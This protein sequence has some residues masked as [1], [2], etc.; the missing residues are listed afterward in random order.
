RKDG[1]RN[2]WPGDT[3]GISI[4][5]RTGP[6]LMLSWGVRS[7]AGYRKSG[8]LPRPCDQGS[9]PVIKAPTRNFCH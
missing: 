3:T 1:N 9:G 8:P 4:L 6:K 5:S 2:V 7:V